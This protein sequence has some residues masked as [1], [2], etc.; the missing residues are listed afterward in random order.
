MTE[1][2]KRIAA[3]ND[4]CRTAMGVAGQLLITPGISSLPLPDQSS[5]LGKVQKFDDFSR[6]N[7]PYSERDFGAFDHAGK[8]IFWKIDYYDPTFTQGSEDPADPKK[9]A[10]VLTVLL[11]EEW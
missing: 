4:L 1:K 3:L 8:K 11:A 6:N 5:I 7:D 10:R 2:T 9:T